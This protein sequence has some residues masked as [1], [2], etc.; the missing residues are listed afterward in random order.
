MPFNTLL[1]TSLH[2]GTSASESGITVNAEPQRGET[3]LFFRTDNSIV[4]QNLNM[5]KV[6]DYLVFYARKNE[7]K[8]VLCFVEMKGTRLEDATEQIIKSY[9]HINELLRSSSFQQLQYILWKAYICTDGQAPKEIQKCSNQLKRAF[10]K[11]N[12][13]IARASDLGPLLRR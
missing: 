11:N 10:G 1:L 6:C 12:Y 4:R 13:S 8:K 2:H 7:Q 3:I 9:Q 5:T